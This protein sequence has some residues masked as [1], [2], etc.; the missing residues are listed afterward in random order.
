PVGMV[1][2]AMQMFSHGM[3]TAMLFFLVGVVYDRA[4]HR[5]ID[6]FGG[7]GAVVP[8]Y[9]AFVS[10]AFFASLGLPGLSGFIAEQMVFLGSFQ[11]FRT[12]VII[13][14]LGIIFVAAFH[15]WALQR[16][17]LGPLNPK[18]ATLEEINAREIFCLAPLGILVMIV[19]VWPMPVLSLM[20]ASLV[21]LVDLVKAVI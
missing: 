12:L 10:L 9:T 13:G 5:Q 15:L 8:V 4:H 2:A 14:A 11:V 21:R 19:G 7:L 3:I 18:Y 1:G 16:V 20:N 17:F 6:G